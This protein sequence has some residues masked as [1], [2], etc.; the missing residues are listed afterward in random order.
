MSYLPQLI[1][2]WWGAAGPREAGG[3]RRGAHTHAEAAATAAQ[4]QHLTQ[5]VP[6]CKLQGCRMLA[7]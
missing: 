3:G 7:F 2:R 5:I 1:V 4:A 6:D